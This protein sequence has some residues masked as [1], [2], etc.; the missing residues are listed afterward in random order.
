MTGLPLPIVCLLL[1]VTSRLMLGVFVQQLLL[2]GIVCRLT[3][4]L[5]KLSQHFVDT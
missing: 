3:S 2:S 5:A 4:I 1:V